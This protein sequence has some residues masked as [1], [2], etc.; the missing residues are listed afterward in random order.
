M[1]RQKKT[2]SSDFALYSEETPSIHDGETGKSNQASVEKDLREIGKELHSRLLEKTDSRV[3]ASIS[4]IFFPLL[5]KSLKSSFHYLPDSHVIETIA[6]DTLIKYLE[7]PEKFDPSKRSL[8]GYLFMDAYWD[9]KNLIGRAKKVVELY[10]QVAE[11]EVQAV[12]H[13]SNPESLFLEQEALQVSEDSEWSDIVGSVIREPTDRAILELL[14]D[15]V[16]ETRQFAEVLGV[17]KLQ[18]KQQARLVKRHKDRIKKII[19][20]ALKKRA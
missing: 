20:R 9:V 19:Q 2:S 17:E 13:D 10:P 12:A 11:Y 7:K 4:E 18:P 6:E 3:T 8:I 5:V 15:G 16:R 1:N 14:L